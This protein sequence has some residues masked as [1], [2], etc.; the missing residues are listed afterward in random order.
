MAVVFSD[1]SEMGL[2][3]GKGLF[4][5]DASPERELSILERPFPRRAQK[6]LHS[7]RRWVKL[8]GIRSRRLRGTVYHPFGHTL[9][10]APLVCRIVPVPVEIGE[11]GASG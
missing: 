4:C 9:T 3:F 10:K 11:A 5:S 6:L 8:K 7:R 2:E 1:V